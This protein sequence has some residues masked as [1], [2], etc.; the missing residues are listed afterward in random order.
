MD[1]ADSSKEGTI[2]S[3]S[4]TSIDT[5]AF[6]DDLLTP[7]SSEPDMTHFCHAATIIAR[8]RDRVW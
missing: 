7:A 2:L 6:S 8:K 5:T 4:A 1:G 3:D